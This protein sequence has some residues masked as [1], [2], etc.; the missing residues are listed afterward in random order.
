MPSTT[1]NVCACAQTGAP[2]GP[3]S[4]RPSRIEDGDGE[5]GDDD[6]DDADDAAS[7]RMLTVLH[8]N[9]KGERN[10]IAK[11]SKSQNF[12]RARPKHIPSESHWGI[13]CCERRGCT[14]E[15]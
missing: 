5:D 7:E 4:A 14:H 2:Q 1:T 13:A 8:G 6:N 10:A 3:S 12:A 11:S 15:W 9:G